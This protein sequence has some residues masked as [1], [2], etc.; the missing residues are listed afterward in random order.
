[1]PYL[2]KSALEL[3]SQEYAQLCAQESWDASLTLL[4]LY[5]HD[6]ENR[7]LLELSMAQAK[8][9]TLF[10]AHSFYCYTSSG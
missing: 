7:Y 1:M 6:S 2:N 8:C 4:D 10:V 5:F 3:V 9:G